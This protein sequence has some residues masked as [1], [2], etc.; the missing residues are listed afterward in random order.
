MTTQHENKFRVEGTEPEGRQHGQRSHG[1][2]MIACCI[3]MLAIAIIL[4]ATGIASPIFLLAA[5]SCTLM[6][7]ALMMGSMSHGAGGRS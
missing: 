6:M 3:P 2:M 5:V 7:A 1:L 4:V